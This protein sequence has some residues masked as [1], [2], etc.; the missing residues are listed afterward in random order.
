MWLLGRFC[1]SPWPLCAHLFERRQLCFVRRRRSR[2]FLVRLPALRQA[3]CYMNA[4]QLVGYRKTIIRKL[5]SYRQSRLH[6]PF[7][8]LE[9]VGSGRR[10]LAL[11]EHDANWSMASDPEASTPR[12]VASPFVPPMAL[13][14]PHRPSVDFLQGPKPVVHV[15]AKC[16]PKCQMRTLKVC[17]PKN[18]YA[19]FP[20]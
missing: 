19:K 1:R 16:V 8:E 13:L 18:V 17:T 10:C 4:P 11:G 2:E 14:R 15:G 9:S 5:K 12:C 20:T 3:E 6:W 7:C